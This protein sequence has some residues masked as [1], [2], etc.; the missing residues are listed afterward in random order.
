MR[1]R[2]NDDEGNNVGGRPTLYREE[3]NAQA[4]K[5]CALGATDNEL[6]DFFNVSVRTI[7]GWKVRHE[8]FLRSIKAGKEEIDNRVERSLFQRA[9]G[10]EHDAVK[11]FMPAGASEPVYAPYRERVGP[12]TTACIFWLKNRRRAEWRDKIDHEHTGA[13][14]GPIS[15]IGGAMT[16]EQAAEAYAATLRGN[17]G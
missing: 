1:E 15:V 3:Y 5:L 9:V 10:Y 14:G 11:I 17:G 13:D 2:D 16:P 8:G 4:E 6:A 12:D 7:D